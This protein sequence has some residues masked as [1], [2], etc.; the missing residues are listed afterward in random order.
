[1]KAD[2][3]WV[4]GNSLRLLENGED[5]FPA[6]FNAIAQAR[7]EV[8]LETFILFE[9]KVGLALHAVLL[10][11]ARR[12]VQVEVTIDG[13]GSP[14]LSSD[15]IHSLTEAGVRLHVFDPPP[16]L[17]RRL[18]PF[19]RLHRKIV[20]VDGETGFI[21]GINYS[22]D[23]LGDFGPQAKQD[24]AVQ[25]RGP[26]VAHMRREAQRMIAP[27]HGQRWW[28]RRQA[29]ICLPEETPSAGPA[30][31]KLVTR[32]NHRHRDDIER[33][34]RLA[35][36]AARREVV[37]ANA[38]F[39]P[40]Y[41]LVRALQ[42]AARRGVAVHLILQGEPDIPLAAMASRMVYQ[43]LIQSGVSIHEYCQRPLH[44]KVATVDGEWATIGSSNLDP[45][46][47]SLNLEANLMVRDPGFTRELR[48]TL[49]TL[50]DRHCQRIAAQH[51]ASWWWSWLGYPVFHL[52]RH[53]PRWASLLP[54]HRPLL[55]PAQHSTVVV[56]VAVD[57]GVEPWPWQP[58]GQE[59]ASPSS[60]GSPNAPLRQRA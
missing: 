35:L 48:E 29:E 60:P 51:V 33:H 56:P 9:D 49:M 53:F 2:E 54:R 1:M 20:V 34:Y 15:F 57:T 30:R 45:L 44:A 52:L 40:G 58:P 16:K 59:S 18:Q 42:R 8:L 10:D 21:G 19:R 11:A 38:Y 41:R 25:V 39:F 23:H 4:D 31:A 3:G 24:Y 37:I 28:Q 27:A 26:I 47:L 50:R 55:T 6:V 22:A 43:R 36:H 46:S 14:M 17:S 5:F 12:G 32:D 13:F 7:R